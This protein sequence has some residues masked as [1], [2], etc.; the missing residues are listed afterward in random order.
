VY[1]IPVWSAP[2]ELVDGTRVDV[3][4]VAAPGAAPRGPALMF[5][6]WNKF[7]FKEREHPFHFPELGA[8]FCRAYDEQAGTPKVASFTLVDDVTPPRGE[9]GAP[10]TPHRREMWH[11]VCAPETAT[12]TAGAKPSAP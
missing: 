4:T 5:S 2:G 3:L 11:Q 6:R 7:T 10:T 8:Y 1:D 9:D 12:E